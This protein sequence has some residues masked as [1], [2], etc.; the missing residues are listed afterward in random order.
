[1]VERP[2]TQYAYAGEVSIA[3][4]RSAAGPIDVVVTPGFATHLEL[5]WEPPYSGR[6]FDRFARFS[7][8][9]QVE[10][11][12][13]GLSDH[14]SEPATLEQ[15]MD[16]L[17]AVMDAEGIE[18]AALVGISEGASMS[19]LFAATYPERVSSLVLWS[20][21]VGPPP[22]EEFRSWLLPWVQ[23]SWGSGEVMSVL[24]RVGSEADIERLGKLERY[25][26]SP[27][28]ARA[29]VEMNF[30]NDIRDVLPVISAPTLVVH[31]TGDPVIAGERAVR[32]AELVAGARRVELPGDWHISLIAGEEDDAIDII[33]EFITGSRPAPTVDFDRVL[34]TVLFTDIVDSTRRAESLG[35]RR[36]RELLDAHDRAAAGEIERHRGIMVKTTGDGVLA[37]FDGPAR[38]IQCAQAIIDAAGR[39]D[40]RVRAGL[41]VGE[42]ELR[43]DDVAGIAVHIGA[44]VSALAGAGEVLVS[45]TVRDLVAGSGIAFEDRGRHT[46]KGVH[47]DWQLL[48]VVPS[49]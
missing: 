6:I 28:M 24:V 21:G 32:L 34:A 27:H 11:R 33:E 10:K 48:A 40:L 37:R 4:C 3:Y 14:I 16:D 23:D 17:R 12:G 9:T 41:H 2:K 22:T 8:V 46:L 26:M 49:A 36:W 38:G 25:S 5:M 44:R 19:A 13:V 30:E 43:G 39:L 15:R 35:D 18:R 45:S 42:C 29:L 31:R 7:R 20:A 47:G 1:M